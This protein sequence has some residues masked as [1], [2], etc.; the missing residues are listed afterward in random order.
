MVD[1]SS[2][3]LCQMIVPLIESSD[4]DE[5]NSFIILDCNNCMYSISNNN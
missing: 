5:V 4:F 1:V 3:A 2:R